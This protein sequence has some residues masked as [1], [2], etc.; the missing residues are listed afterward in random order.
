M[1][2][3]LA[4]FPQTSSHERAP[5][6]SQRRTILEYRCPPS[7]P[8]VFLLKKNILNGSTGERKRDKFLQENCFNHR[9]GGVV[10]A[11]LRCCNCRLLLSGN[12]S[13]GK[14]KEERTLDNDQQ[15]SVTKRGF[16]KKEALSYVT[17]QERR[18]LHKHKKGFLGS[19]H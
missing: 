15:N 1:L 14:R 3:N 16:W 10:H 18:S 17:R 19:L 2:C 5:V 8:E 11:E 6:L 9:R 7:R 12:F 4:I 13:A